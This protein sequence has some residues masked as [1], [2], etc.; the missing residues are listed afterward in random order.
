M[1]YRIIRNNGKIFTEPKK[2]D[3]ELSTLPFV[4]SKWDDVEN[5]IQKMD[6]YFKRNGSDSSGKIKDIAFR[7]AKE[8]LDMAFDPEG[9]IISPQRSNH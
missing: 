5:K 6:T 8:S 9:E 1:E 4:S 2:Y 7:G 3:I